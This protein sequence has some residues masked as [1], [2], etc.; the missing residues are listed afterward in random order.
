[1]A[2]A[3]AGDGF[4]VVLVGRRSAPLDQLF[5]ELQAGGADGLVTPADVGDP[6]QAA[7]A[8]DAAAEKFRGID[9]LSTSP[10]STAC[11][12][13]LAGPRTACRRPV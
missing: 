4:G 8:V 1:V 6:D 3:L 13:A 12:R 2:H 9:L 10:R 11:S 5:D 7:A